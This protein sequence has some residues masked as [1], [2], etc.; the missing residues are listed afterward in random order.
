MTTRPLTCH[1]CAAAFH[2]NEKE[3]D[4]K[5]LPTHQ[6]SLTGRCIENTEEMQAESQDVMKMLMQND[7]QQCFQSWNRCV[8][9]ERGYFE[10]DGGD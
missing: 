9:A 6:N 8:N 4:S 5:T 10:G 3:S 7:F 2:F 1:P